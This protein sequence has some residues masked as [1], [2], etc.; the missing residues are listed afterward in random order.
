MT[1]PSTWG[2]NITMGKPGHLSDR[3][4]LNQSIAIPQSQWH[5]P[6][7]V[8]GCSYQLYKKQHWGPI[9]PAQTQ[10]IVWSSEKIIGKLKKCSL[11]AVTA[12]KAWLKHSVSQHVNMAL[13][14]E[15]D[16]Y[17]RILVPRESSVPAG[18]P[19]EERHCCTLAISKTAFLFILRPTDGWM[20]LHPDYE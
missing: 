1:N 6:V 9:E 5:V 7:S 20:E 4:D 8:K 12:F 16:I 17:P 11:S 15:K 2:G 3:F 10:S 13:K 18:A 19:S 14:G